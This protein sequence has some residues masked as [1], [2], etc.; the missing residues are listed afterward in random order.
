MVLNMINNRGITY[1]I[2]KMHKEKTKEIAVPYQ[3]II[4]FIIPGKTQGQKQ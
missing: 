1:L 3:L 2:A 4:N